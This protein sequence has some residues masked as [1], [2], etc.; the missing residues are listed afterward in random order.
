MKE[1]KWSTHEQGSAEWLSERLGK[2]T[3]SRMA[4]AMKTLKKGGESE[5]RKKLKLEI[6]AEQ[7][8]GQVVPVFLNDAMKWG[9]TYEADA[10]QEYADETGNM[11]DICGL[12]LHPDIN[13]FGASPDGLIGEDG[14]LEIKCPTSITFLQWVL[15]GVVP[16]QHK[17]QMLAQLAVTGRKWCDF[18]A[19]DPRFNAPYNLFIRRFEPTAEEITATETAAANFLQEIHFLTVQFL[20]A[21]K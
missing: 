18:V 20:G 7:L 19:Y 5:E 6:M 15:D 4:T 13:N 12:A 9:N 11:V 16:E 14:I 17:P 2:L 8:T 3:A 10:R 1:C 21:I